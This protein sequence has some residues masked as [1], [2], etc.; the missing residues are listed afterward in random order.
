MF[1]S[2]KFQKTWNT[3]NANKRAFVQVSHKGYLQGGVER[4]T[5]AAHTVAW[6][7]YY[8]EW[9]DTQI[10]HIDG[11]RTNNAISNLRLATPL[12]NGRNRRS[13]D[14][15]TSKFTGVSWN[16]Q[17]Q[18]W[19]AQICGKGAPGY[20]GAFE[21]EVEAAAAYDNAA[22]EFYGEFAHQNLP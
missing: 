13:G 5:V 22:K 14:A 18:K 19:V 2:E 7:M 8:G 11:N 6:A 3:K 17:R 10:D 15:A 20:L 12:E 4:Y 16:T 9:P 21:S 1:R